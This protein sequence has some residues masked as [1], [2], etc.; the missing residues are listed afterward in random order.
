MS[1]ITTAVTATTVIDQKNI[2]PQR[3]CQRPSLRVSIATGA[4]KGA[5]TPKNI[6]IQ[7][8]TLKTKRLFIAPANALKSG[9]FPRNRPIKR[10]HGIT[11][12][13]ALVVAHDRRRRNSDTGRVFNPC[14][15]LLQ[16]ASLELIVE[17]QLQLHP[18]LLR[19]SAMISQFFTP[20]KPDN[21]QTCHIEIC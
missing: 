18:S 8:T 1:D 17:T 6:C 21:T 11:R 13:V 15:C 19:L 14:R 20:T 2:L 3:R 16:A 10:G 5:K 12:K 9:R 7:R 4:T